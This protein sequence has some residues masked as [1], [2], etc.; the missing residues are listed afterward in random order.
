MNNQTK[1]Q[2]VCKAPFWE[3]GGH[4]K[5]GRDLQRAFEEASISASESNCSVDIKLKIAVHPPKRENVGAVQYELVISQPK[6][7]SI[8]FEAQY[9]HGIIIATEDPDI[10]VMQQQL[11][12]PE[13][14]QFLSRKEGTDNQNQE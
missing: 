13:T 2:P 6:F 8:M 7:K 10:G 14:A 1:P 12:L 4:G 9:D 5:L 11:K 3:I